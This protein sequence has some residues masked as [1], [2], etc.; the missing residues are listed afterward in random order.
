MSRLY[1]AERRD[2]LRISVYRDG[3][4]DYV[5]GDGGIAVRFVEVGDFMLYE[6]DRKNGGRG[7]G[8]RR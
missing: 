6:G 5:C 1:P 4:E 7:E 8:V 3:G 2:T